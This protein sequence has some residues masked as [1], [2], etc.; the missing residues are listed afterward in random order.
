MP[1][2]ETS[3]RTPSRGRGRSV[4]AIVAVVLSLAALTFGVIT[5]GHIEPS[6]RI[7]EVVAGQRR[8]WP[9]GAIRPGDQM[10]CQGE[11][12]ELWHAGPDDAVSFGDTGITVGHAGD[13]SI[14]ATC[15]KKL[16]SP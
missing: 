3:P 4:I 15:P 5:R 16:P 7:Y 13:G 1:R 11:V 12:Y 8:Y 9:P 10:R 2:A 6:A 14:I